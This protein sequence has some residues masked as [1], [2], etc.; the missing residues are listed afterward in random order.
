MAFLKEFFE[1]VNFEKKLCTT[2][3]CKI[4]LEET[5]HW[6]FLI[7]PLYSHLILFSLS[8]CSFFCMDVQPP[9]PH[10]YKWKVGLIQ[11]NDGLKMS[12]DMRFPTIWFVRPAKPQISLHI[13]AVWSEPLLVT[14][15]FYECSATDWTPFGVSKL[16]RRLHRLVWVYTPQNATLLEITCQGSNNSHHRSAGDVEPLFSG[17]IKNKVVSNVATI[18]H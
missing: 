15:I 17:T 9:P 8:F 13:R 7:L 5:K 16:Q 2:K 4:K 10:L 14:W 18:K 12:C 6:S 11:T 1:N 3:T